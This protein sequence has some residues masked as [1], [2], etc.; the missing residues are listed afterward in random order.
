[1]ARINLLPWREELRRK[2]RDEFLVLLSIAALIAV[3]VGVGV[4][5]YYDGLIRYQ[6]QR[7]TFLEQRIAQLA[8]KIKEIA[9]IEK[10]R[11]KLVE[12][13]R[14]IEQ[15]QEERPGIVKLF[16]ALVQT[17]PESVSLNSFV[18]KDRSLVFQGIATSNARVS[19]YMKRMEGSEV[20]GGP[21][22]E[23]IETKT[24]EGNRYADFQLKAE[25]KVAKAEPDAA[26]AKP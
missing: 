22:L 14:A 6:N 24:K 7:N 10:R 16:D 25:Q 12:R 11:D 9:E 8:I 5:M 17:L 18:Q 15:L 4:H 23:F 20:I 19:N 26:E 13:I 3:C 2:R 1:M 21:K